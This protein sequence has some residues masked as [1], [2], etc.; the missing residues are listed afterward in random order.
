[1]QSRLL[2]LGLARNTGG[3]TAAILSQS[4]LSVPLPLA[5]LSVS[6]ASYSSLSHPSLLLLFTTRG[7]LLTTTSKRERQD[8]A[9]PGQPK[10]KKARWQGSLTI[11]PDSL[12]ALNSHVKKPEDIISFSI[13]QVKDWVKDIV[14][15]D[16]KNAMILFDGEMDGPALLN[17]DSAMKLKDLYG[18]APAS[19][20]KLCSAIQH[21]KEEPGTIPTVSLSLF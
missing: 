16:E 7:L 8:T 5:L 20:D 14:G 18:I 4:C 3:G 21:L 2:L 17:V 9:G 13:A 15:L 10:E 11:L 19:A 6:V 1:M 12:F